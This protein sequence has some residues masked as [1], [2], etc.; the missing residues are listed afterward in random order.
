MEVE[1]VKQAI[2]ALS[3]ALGDAG[4]AFIAHTEAGDLAGVR[5]SREEVAARAS[6]LRALMSQLNPEWEPRL[7]HDMLQLAH[8][9]ESF[10]ASR[11]AS[12]RC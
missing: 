8:W 9:W 3:R 12:P 10:A 4:H 6:A 11:T 1:S 7:R 2:F 5:K